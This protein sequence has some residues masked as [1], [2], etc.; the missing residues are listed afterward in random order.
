MTFSR[1]S[2]NTTNKLGED[3]IKQRS[4]KIY[5]KYKDGED[6]GSLSI[7]SKDVGQL[8]AEFT[9]D[10]KKYRKQKLTRVTKDL[11]GPGVVQSQQFSK[12]KPKVKRLKNNLTISGRFV[13]D[14]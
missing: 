9:L 1:V 13:L 6:I 11:A 8:V 4:V 3:V 2:K 10:Y 12:P 14:K 7:I 5:P